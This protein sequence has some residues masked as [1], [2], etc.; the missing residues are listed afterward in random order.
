MGTLIVAE[1]V[2]VDGAAQRPG[3]PMSRALSTSRCR[4][5]A[6]GVAGPGRAGLASAPFI[7]DFGWQRRLNALATSPHGTWRVTGLAS[8]F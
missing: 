3:V 1:F 8:A 6:P 2:T 4:S 5:L 7:D